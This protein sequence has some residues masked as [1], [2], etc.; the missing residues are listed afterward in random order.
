M[1]EEKHEP[2][3]DTSTMSFIRTAAIYIQVGLIMVV[4]VYLCWAMLGGCDAQFLVS[5]NAGLAKK[6]ADLTNSGVSGEAMIIK[7]LTIL[8]PHMHWFI[9]ALGSSIICFPLL[10]LLLGRSLN[11]PN[12]AGLLPIF[13]LFSGLNPAMMTDNDLVLPMSLEKQMI[14]L[15][16]QIIC[17]HFFADFAARRRIAK[18]LEEL[19]DAL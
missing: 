16:V 11:Q 15:F 6:V 13:G 9:M 8:A 3:K 7:M 1:S 17:I 14:V 12:I 19:A 10:G 5:T 4:A 2:E 18:E